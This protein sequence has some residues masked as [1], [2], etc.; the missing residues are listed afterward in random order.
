MPV[1]SVNVIDIVKEFKELL[2]SVHK[3]NLKAVILYGSMARGDFDD[4][5]D[6]D[7]LVVLNDIS[8]YKKEFEKT[9]QV[10]RELEMKYDDNIIIGCVMAKSLDYETRCEPLYLNIRKEGIVV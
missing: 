3:D 7:V 9:F 5:S 8:D 6:I 1:L 2:E 10:Q 4:E